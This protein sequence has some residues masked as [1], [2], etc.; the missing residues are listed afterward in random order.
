MITLPR[1]EHS[2]SHKGRQADAALQEAGTGIQ[3][4]GRVQ[5]FFDDDDLRFFR[6]K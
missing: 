4:N 3:L 5:T 6:K 1:T 2:Q